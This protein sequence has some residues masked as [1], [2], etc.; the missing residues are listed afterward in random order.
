MEAVQ[1]EGERI[2]LRE[3]AR[4][5]WPAIHA[6]ASRPEVC[7]YQPWGPNTPDETVAFVE[8]AVASAEECPRRRYALA[9]ALQG[10]DEV[11][12]LMELYVRDVRSGVGEIA[13]VLRP[14]YWGQGITMESALALLRF[15]FDVLGLHRIFATCDPRNVASSRV[16]EKSGMTYEGRMRETLLIRDGWRDSLMYAILEHEWRDGVHK[17]LAHANHPE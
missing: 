5:D 4:A 16:M 2:T 12:G 15:G 3:L 6:Y 17:A 1:L 8:A 7:R 14:E 11:I 13:W 10:T 9:V